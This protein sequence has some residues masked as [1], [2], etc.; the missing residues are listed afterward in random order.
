M[1]EN[2]TKAR[3][4]RVDTAWVQRWQQQLR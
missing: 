1:R 4:A 3:L 2:L